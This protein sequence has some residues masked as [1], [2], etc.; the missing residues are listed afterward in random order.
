MRPC[1]SVL[2]LS[3]CPATLAA[4]QVA[5]TLPFNAASATIYSLIVYGLAGLK[6]EAQAVVLNVVVSVLL[7]LIAVQVTDT[8][9]WEWCSG[10]CVAWLTIA[11]APAEAH[12]CHAWLPSAV[13]SHLAEWLCC[14]PACCPIP[15]L[16]LA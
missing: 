5:A 13:W 12:H 7:S 3:C 15:E 9:A 14:A 4:L 16:F 11:E 8:G 1:H 6:S 2:L 10:C